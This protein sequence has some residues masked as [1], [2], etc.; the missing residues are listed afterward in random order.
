MR[1]IHA[2][3][4]SCQYSNSEDARGRLANEARGMCNPKNFPRFDMRHLHFNNQQY[5]TPGPVTFCAAL[6]ENGI[7]GHKGMRNYFGDRVPGS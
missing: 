6:Q 1:E 5:R 7:S 2:Q 3:A 4:T